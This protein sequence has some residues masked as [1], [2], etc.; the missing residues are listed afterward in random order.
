MVDSRADPDR[1]GGKVIRLAT[2]VRRRKEEIYI[3]K[4]ETKTDAG[5]Y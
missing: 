5:A 3:E 4:I 1:G 2:G